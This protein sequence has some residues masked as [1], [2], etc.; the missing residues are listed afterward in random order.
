MSEFSKAQLRRLKGK[1]DRRHVQT[2]EVDGRSVYYIE[3]WFAIAQANAIFGF[4]GWDR[5]MTHFERIYE[6][7]RGDVTSCA[8]VAR[9]QIRVR[10]SRAVI[11]REGTGSGSAT[12]SSSGEAHDL[13]LKAA[14]TDA[15]KRALATFGDSF[16]LSLY[17]KAQN[18]VTGKKTS[19]R[20]SF[21]LNDPT[22]APF[23]Q[24][25]SPEAFCSGLRQL[26]QATTT[27][28]ELEALADRNKEG[29]ARLRTDAPTLKTSKDIHYAEI[30][31]RL[32]KD[33][34]LS[35][36]PSASANGHKADTNSLL[37]PENKTKL[38][39]ESSLPSSP[40]PSRAPLSPLRPSKIA[41]GPRIDK[42]RLPI[43]TERRLRD[44]AHLMFVATQ[45]CLICGRKPSQAHH[46]TFCQKRGLS[47]KVGD[48]FCVPLCA[49]HHYE[50]H[51]GGPERAWWEAKGIIPEPIAAELW[52]RSRV[53]S[54]LGLK[55]AASLQPAQSTTTPSSVDRMDVAVES[56]P[57]NGAAREPAD[58]NP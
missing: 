3:G 37:P 58:R 21:T 16:G 13:A 6:R 11:V 44:K 47:L 17:D 1:L 56:L 24:N 14:E 26:V 42:S 38:S 46:L 2:R 57:R 52:G 55:P 30:L 40:E 32:I 31:E 5:E 4:A 53:P 20:N 36:P 29:V 50:L 9:V 45:P 54:A 41:S 12:A 51:R 48:Q 18:G 10:T 43:G 7:S 15:T 35:P 8:Y 19:A 49:L 27:H 28:A 22:G 34:L 33:R 23:A 25:L 39:S